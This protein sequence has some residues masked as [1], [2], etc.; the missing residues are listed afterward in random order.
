[1]IALGLLAIGAR[2]LAADFVFLRNA[3][4]DTLE[5][6]KQDLREIFTGKTKSWKNG[7]KI[8]IGL[9]PAGSAELKWIAQELISASEDILLLKIKQETFK[10]DMK[11]PTP[12]A[13]A[14]ECIALVKKSAGGICVVDAD[15]ARTLPDDVAILK[16][17]K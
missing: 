12:I 1:M 2:V 4:N 9:P 8:D 15:S 11:R 3:H 16:Y 13:S 7:Q 17:T 14:S 6:S 5:A 10:G